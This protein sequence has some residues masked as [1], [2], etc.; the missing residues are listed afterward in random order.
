[1][2]WY[3][4][5]K[6]VKCRFLCLPRDHF[7]ETGTIKHLFLHTHDAYAARDQTR[8]VE[9]LQ[10]CLQCLL[11]MS[12][13]QATTCV[14]VSN[15]IESSNA[16]LPPPQHFHFV[17]LKF[18]EGASPAPV[19]CDKYQRLS[20]YLP[21]CLSVIFFGNDRDTNSQVRPRETLPFNAVRPQ[22]SQQ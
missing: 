15:S 22:V 3:P 2:W 5:F 13:A 19:N 18:T 9:L 7:P 12:Y 8:A 11:R 14:L 16:A 10:P 21:V 20:L 4:Y 6:H 1:M 17:G